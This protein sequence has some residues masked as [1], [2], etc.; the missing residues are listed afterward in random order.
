MC[1]KCRLVALF[2]DMW[3]TVF[4]YVVEDPHCASGIFV[5]CLL[6]QCLKHQMLPLTL[7]CF[8]MML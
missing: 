1:E 8:T 4:R 2:S 7:P 5:L 6:P 3:C